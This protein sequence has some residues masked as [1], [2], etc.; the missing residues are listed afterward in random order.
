MSPQ[1]FPPPGVRLEC[2]G[3]VRTFSHHYRD[4]A[5]QSP[6]AIPPKRRWG[7][8][9]PASPI[10]GAADAAVSSFTSPP[11]HS[12]L[13]N[14][15]ILIDPLTGGLRAR[16]SSENAADEV[17]KPY[18][19]AGK[20]VF[21]DSSTGGVHHGAPRR[22]LSRA[23]RRPHPQEQQQ[24]RERWQPLLTDPLTGGLKISARVL[25]EQQQQR[26]PPPEQAGALE[27]DPM[28]GGLVKKVKKGKENRGL[29]QQQQQQQERHVRA[30]RQQ[31]PEVWHED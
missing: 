31:H 5:M 24:E 13:V 20:V 11:P 15:A 12:A 19:A 16:L 27:V 8:G 30:Q 9:A 18:S 1:L 3:S 4:I 23:P 26:P 28:T 22:P 17:P 6:H 25:R 14:N 7:R 10:L 21:V 2:T 29:Q